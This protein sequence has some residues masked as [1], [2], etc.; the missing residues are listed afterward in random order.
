[1][2]SP[3]FHNLTSFAVD[4]P[5]DLQDEFRKAAML[6]YGVRRG[7]LTP[8]L[9]EALQDFIQKINAEEKKKSKK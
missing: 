7:Y 9:Q 8:A 5:D 3:H 2:Y 6:K 1:M 4:V